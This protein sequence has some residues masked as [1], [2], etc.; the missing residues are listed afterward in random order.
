MM[1]VVSSEVG[2]DFS[3]SSSFLQGE[4]YKV[5]ETPRPPPVVGGGPTHRAINHL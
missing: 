4:V 1:L 2:A 5:Q 3:L